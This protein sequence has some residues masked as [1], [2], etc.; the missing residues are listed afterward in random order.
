MA[1]ARANPAI[2]AVDHGDVLGYPQAE[3]PIKKRSM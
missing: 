2:I 3:L 1:A